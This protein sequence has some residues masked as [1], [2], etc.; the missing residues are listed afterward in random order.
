MYVYMSEVR[1]VELVRTMVTVKLGGNL[2]KVPYFRKLVA[3]VFDRV[4]SR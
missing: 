2:V 3:F 4:S 1:G